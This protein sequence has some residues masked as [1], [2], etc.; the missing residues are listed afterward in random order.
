[1]KSIEERAN[2]YAERICA[3]IPYDKFSHVKEDFANGARSEHNELTRWNKSDVLP[4]KD[5]IC[6]GK[7]K[8]Y[9]EEIY[10]LLIYKSEQKIFISRQTF[11][12]IMP[13][14]LIGWREIHE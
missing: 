13:T 14:D 3:A 7:I 12:R 9:D 1:M 6:L 11:L 8:Y 4:D 5:M 2:E 10:E